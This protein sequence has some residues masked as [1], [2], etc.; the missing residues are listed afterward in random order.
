[1]VGKVNKPK[2]TWGRK[3]KKKETGEAADD[4]SL[5]GGELRVYVRRRRDAVALVGAPLR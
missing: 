5:D 4:E 3:T 2:T 1:M